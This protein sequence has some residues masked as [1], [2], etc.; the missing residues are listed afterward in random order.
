MKRYK[1]L[2]GTVLGALIGGGLGYLVQCSGGLCRIMATPWRG[3]AVGAV[4]GLLSAVNT[5][6]ARK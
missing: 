1:L 4:I 5:R 2:M 6:Q 3:M